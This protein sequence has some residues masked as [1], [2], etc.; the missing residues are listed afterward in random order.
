MRKLLFLL[1]LIGALT[2]TAQK[3]TDYVSFRGAWLGYSISDSCRSIISVNMPAGKSQKWAMDSGRIEI[4]GDTMAVIRYLLKNYDSLSLAADRNKW[5]LLESET[6][7]R[8]AIAAVMKT[9]QIMDG[10]PEGPKMA[11]AAAAIKAYYDFVEA[12]FKKKTERLH[13]TTK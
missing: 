7:F 12:D 11:K 2:A 6:Y 8:E 13:L 10:K 4:K 1:P 9:F 5:R 3:D